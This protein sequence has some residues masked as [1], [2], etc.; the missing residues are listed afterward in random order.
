M[1]FVITI[2]VLFTC[3]NADSQTLFMVY[4]IDGK[5]FQ[6]KMGKKIPIRIGNY[7]NEN[8]S[9]YLQSK[10]S[11]KFICN[12]YSV[13]DVNTPNI[14]VLK[15]LVGDCKNQ[16]NSFD[17]DYFKFVWEQFSYSHVNPEENR[18]KNMENLGGAIRGCSGLDFEK[19]LDSVKYW[20]GDFSL[21]WKLFHPVDSVS[22]AFYNEDYSEIPAIEFPIK[23]NSF[24]VSNLTKKG[25]SPGIYY[26]TVNL[27]NR[28]DCP[29]KYIEI[30]TDLEFIKLIDTIRNNIG[31]PLDKADENYRIGFQLEKDHFYYEAFRFYMDALKADPENVLYKNTIQTV[32]SLYHL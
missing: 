30:W 7:F 5:A 25:L 28:N 32:K 8:D 29:K 31:V 11:V 2:L 3:I 14:I 23:N 20:S 6:I 12:K 26:W 19:Y 10:T 13:V 18:K 4:K 17:A 1:K 27:N 16:S 24:N 9:I 21:I 15:K 22:I